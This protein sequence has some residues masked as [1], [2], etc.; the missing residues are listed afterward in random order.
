MTLVE[1]YSTTLRSKRPLR[2]GDAYE[3]RS[4][5]S[6]TFDHKAKTE[7]ATAVFNE[8]ERQMGYFKRARGIQ[9]EVITTYTQGHAENSGRHMRGKGERGMGW[10]RRKVWEEK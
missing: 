2:R 4:G 6:W 1:K 5:G 9:R 10:L 8:Q 7:V 3:T